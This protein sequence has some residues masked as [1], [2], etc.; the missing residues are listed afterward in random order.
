MKRLICILVI[1]FCFN[2]VNGQIE[3]F[4]SNDFNYYSNNATGAFGNYD[5][6]S[7][8]IINQFA[9]KFYTGGYINDELKLAV[10][11]RTKNHN[12]IGGNL[13]YGIFHTY[14]IPENK[15]KLSIFFSLKNRAHFDMGF[16][17]NLFELGFFGNAQFAGQTANINNSSINILRYQQ[18]QFGIF[19]S[20]S[21]SV[22]R[23]GIGISVLKGEQYLTIQ[24]KKGELFTSSDGQNIN[25]NAELFTAQSDTAHK[26]ITAFN[27][28]GA[29]LDL[30]FEAP[31]D[32]KI[33]KSKIKITVSDIGSIYYNNKTILRKQDSTFNYSGFDI[34]GIYDLRD[35]TLG[36]RIKDSVLEAII[37]AKK[38]T[39][40]VT[41]PTTLNF[42]FETQLHPVF[43]LTEGIQYVFNANYKLQFYLI[44][45]F[46]INRKLI[47][48]SQFS[49]GGYGTYNYGIGVS[50]N[51]GKGFI[52]NAGSK[53][54]EGYIVPKITTGQGVY[55]TL[56]KKFK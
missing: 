41:I 39:H 12:Q 31:Y 19:S 54:I 40:S 46:Y 55:F 45:K 52:L 2:N 10:L 7:N 13:N 29:G 30:F 14:K 20:K 26:G 56:I 37:P 4:F 16:S 38:Q 34:K 5:L 42:S 24:S 48:S 49:Y 28:I 15:Q 33:G 43:S 8:S 21:D 22:A 27:G 18:L 9:N 23:W 53:N 50:A 3:D 35:S 11:K 36:N 32:T 47:V 6:N 25:L 17:K 1:S 51:L 44:G